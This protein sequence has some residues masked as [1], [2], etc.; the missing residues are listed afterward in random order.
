M[1]QQ[2]REGAAAVLDQVPEE[3]AT[4]ELLYVRRRHG[5][6]YANTNLRDSLPD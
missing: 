6:S 4:P 1:V 5:R 3:G 2:S